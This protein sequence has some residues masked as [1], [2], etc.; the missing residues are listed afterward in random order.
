[1]CAVCSAE[2]YWSFYGAIVCDPC[3][4]F[5]RRQVLSDKVCTNK[6]SIVTKEN[7]KTNEDLSYFFL[8]PLFCLQSQNCVITELTRKSCSFCR[9]QKSLR[10]GMK[11]DMVEQDVAPK[12]SMR[13]GRIGKY[14]AISKVQHPLNNNIH[15]SQS[16]VKQIQ[17]NN[18]TI[19][20]YSSHPYL[21]QP[22]SSEHRLVQQTQRSGQVYNLFIHDEVISGNSAFNSSNSFLHEKS[23]H[24]VPQQLQAFLVSQPSPFHPA[25]YQPN[26]PITHEYLWLKKSPSSML[27]YRILEMAGVPYFKYKITIEVPVADGVVCGTNCV[28]EDLLKNQPP[29]DA[30][31]SYNSLLCTRFF[32]RNRYDN[33]VFV[34]NHPLNPSTFF[35]VSVTS[36]ASDKRSVMESMTEEL[37]YKLTQVICASRFLQQV[38]HVWYYDQSSQAPSPVLPP[39]SP[40]SS[41]SW[42]ASSSEDIVMKQL[43]LSVNMEN[44]TKAMSSGIELLDTFRS[45]PLEDQV[46][47]LKE[48]LFEAGSFLCAHVYSRENNSTAWTCFDNELLFLVHTNV[49]RLSS[50]IQ[51][52][53]KVYDAFHHDFDDFIRK[54]AFVTN[55]LCILCCFRERKGISC[56]EIIRREREL[57]FELLDKYFVAKLSSGDWQCNLDVIWNQIHHLMSQVLSVKVAYER[58]AHDQ[59]K[60]EIERNQS[61][62]QHEYLWVRRAPNSNLEYR[63]LDIQCVAFVGYRVIIEVQVEDGVVL[64]TGCSW[65]DI[66]NSEEK[67]PE[68]VSSNLDTSCLVLKK[69]FCQWRIFQKRHYNIIP[70]SSIFDVNI[71]SSDSKVIVTME[72][73]N[74]VLWKTLSHVIDTAVILKDIL[75]SKFKISSSSC[76]TSKSKQLE[77]VGGWETFS[78]SVCKIAQLFESYRCLSKEQQIRMTKVSVTE[79]VFLQIA[80]LFDK[81]NNSV[82]HPSIMSHLWI[83]TD[84]VSMRKHVKTQSLCDQMLKVMSEFEDFLRKDEIVMA[85]LS[86]LFLFKESTDNSNNILIP[87]ERALFLELLD[88]YIRAKVQSK[89]WITSY[90]VTW[91]ILKEKMAQISNIKSSIESRSLKQENSA[92][93]S[94]PTNG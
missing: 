49:V 23:F 94:L 15:Y 48:G 61:S 59:M 75:C 58:Y 44:F 30:N 12:G 8:Q 50:V 89:E 24:P 65:T 52:L 28:Y 45:L 7:L 51:D 79:V 34:R 84:L 39:S 43:L 21:P 63:V 93:N 22:T 72:T 91:S 54:D 78:L 13:S 5:F 36:I 31:E 3:R 64:G 9:F 76:E 6:I 35:D 56:S 60:V 17:S 29:A 27:H 67:T 81:S 74:S 66:L 26:K 32:F 71:S 38:T 92:S 40:S 42:S 80:A 20:R 68:L 86:L 16:T 19:A 57:Y 14:H 47:L 33:Q 88:K 73:M 53:V 69:N 83:C 82:V 11:P 55:I 37:W 70:E 62:P 77:I 10:V 87:Q 1:M 85:I 90:E 25:I 18:L 2:T 41:S 46:I 4:T